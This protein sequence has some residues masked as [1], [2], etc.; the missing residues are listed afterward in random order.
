MKKL[1]FV[2]LLIVGCNSTTVENPF[3]PVEV[4]A[5]C[6]WG[7]VSRPDLWVC[8][9]GA[10]TCYMSGNRGPMNNPK[11]ADDMTCFIRNYRSGR[12]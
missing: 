3:G 4:A 5:N 1:F 12:E 7:R 9:M 8:D 6:E 2:T 11:V 10:V